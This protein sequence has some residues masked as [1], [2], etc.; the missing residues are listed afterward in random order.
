MIQ[1]I[2]QKDLENSVEK[3]FVAAS[4]IEE[5]VRPLYK[6]LKMYKS[7]GEKESL[8]RKIKTAEK[9]LE[10][11]KKSALTEIV[12]AYELFRVY[13]VGEA[14]TQLDKV[15]QEMH[16]KD[17]WVAVNGSHNKGPHKKTWESFLD[18]IELHKLTIFPCDAAE[19]QQY[20]M[21]QH[22]RKP[23]HVTV[24]AFVT[25]MGLLNDY[26]AYLPMVKDSSM[27]VEDTQR[28]NVPFNKADLAGNVLKANS[29][30]WIN[31]YNLTHL[32]LP[33]SPRL[34]LPDLANIE[35]VMNK[36]RAEL[37]KARGKDS[38]N[39]AGAKSNPKKRASA[40]S[41]E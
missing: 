27:A 3:V 31:Q 4:D 5:K 22:V 13:F 33:K 8:K 28:G 34:L 18:C 25:R 37:A 2:Q 35:R 7:L 16:Q 40:G 23:Q 29:T 41:S 21:Q 20:Y 32:T 30:S 6:K 10:K 26:L 39:L 38:A 14:R 12:K 1:L 19:L 15:V 11:A 36:K 9:D 24:Q 17:H